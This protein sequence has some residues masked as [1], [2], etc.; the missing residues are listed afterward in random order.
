[1]TR[2]AAQNA[3][4][5]NDQMK[6]GDVQ[7]AEDT[8]SVSAEL[9]AAQK[10]AD[11][12]L[13]SLKTLLRHHG[14]P[15]SDTVLRSGMNPNQSTLQPKDVLRILQKLGFKA[16]VVK[17]GPRALSNSDCPGMVF[18]KD[19][20]AAILAS[21]DKEQITL[22]G[23]EGIPGQQAFEHQ[24]FSEVYTGYV[25][26]A[27]PDVGLR[28]DRYTRTPIRARSW[29]WT[30]I[31]SSWWYFTQVILATVLVNMFAIVTPFFVMIVYDRVIPN[32]SLDTLWVLA[33][34]MGLLLTFDFLLKTLR[35]RFVDSAAKKADMQ[36][37][38]QLFEQVLTVQLG[39]RPKSAGS[40]GSTLR[41]FES[42]REFFSSATLI[43]LID[44]PFTFLFLF[45]LWAIS[46]DV[47]LVLFA[48]VPFVIAYGII[49]Q[50]PLHYSTKQY[51]RE[52][53]AKH[54][55]LI[56]TINTLETVRGDG[57][58]R[59]MRQIW[60]DSVDAAAQSAIRT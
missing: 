11:T 26:I 39:S 27:R 29:F 4:L 14:F 2:G 30:P 12:T 46:G 22:A 24:A 50:I 52:S 10:Q 20:G 33:A 59:R 19:G 31:F 8:P 47:A 55:V 13:E 7:A 35:A 57:A 23:Y 18:L 15:K 28:L 44:L 56:E 48:A 32:Q 53:H 9:E 1:M 43:A 34:G 58:E 6:E 51:L 40:F 25:L 5:E 17:R 3:Q 37:G 54:G 38:R 16:R 21:A 36:I 60:A 41:E 42:L 49:V 45:V